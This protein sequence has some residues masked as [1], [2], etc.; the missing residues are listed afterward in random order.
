MHPRGD[1]CPEVDRLHSEK[2]ISP[3]D[4]AARFNW[5][6]CYSPLS[7]N[8]KTT[9]QDHVERCVRE[10]TTAALVGQRKKA[11]PYVKCYHRSRVVLQSFVVVVYARAT[12]CSLFTSQQ[13]DLVPDSRCLLPLPQEDT[14]PMVCS[15]PSL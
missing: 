12:L 10:P 9:P 5:S 15:R 13:K 4:R 2:P 8:T 11:S 14:R 3:S 6:S 1:R 7:P